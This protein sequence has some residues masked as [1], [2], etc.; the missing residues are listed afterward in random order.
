MNF[1]SPLSLMKVKVTQLCLTLCHP[2]D[3]SLP[4]SSVH[5]DFPDKN[6]EVGSLSFLQGIFSPLPP[7]KVPNYTV[8]QNLEATLKKENETCFSTCCINS[9]YFLDIYHMTQRVLGIKYTEV[10]HKCMFLGSLSC[11]NKDLEQRTLEPSAPALCKLG[12]A[13]RAVWST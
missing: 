13:R 12:L 6:T 4:G 2:M 11:H 10:S 1:L 3:H 9:T 7:K 5:G 8:G